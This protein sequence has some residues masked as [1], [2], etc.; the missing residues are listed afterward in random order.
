MNKKMEKKLRNL[1]WALLFSRI[2]ASAWQN[3]MAQWNIEWYNH[4]EKYKEL[5]LQTSINISNTIDISKNIDDEFNKFKN[6]EWKKI[7]EYYGWKT[8]L[9]NK[10]KSGTI[11]TIDVWTIKNILEEILRNDPGKYY[12][13]ELDGYVDYYRDKYCFWFSDP[14]LTAIT[15]L[16]RDVIWSHK[17]QWQIDFISSEIKR[18]M[19]QEILRLYDRDGR[20]ID[21][22]DEI[23]KF[24]QLCVWIHDKI[25]AKLEAKEIWAQ[26]V[27]WKIEKVLS[28]IINMIKKNPD[29]YWYFLSNWNFVI[30]NDKFKNLVLEK[31]KSEFKEYFEGME[32]SW[33]RCLRSIVAFM[34][35][36][37]FLPSWCMVLGGVLA[38]IGKSLADKKTR[39]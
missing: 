21:V 31:T 32:I 28:E 9:E 20:R 4:S 3:A 39:K 22:G 1:W 30:N 10:I 19:P 23:D 34:V 38:D 15:K 14:D 13:R 12:K 18:N 27:K 6:W 25:T 2:F 5:A 8:N 26:V 17:D 33:G 29:D 24:N 35:W 36:A 16:V 37:C 7:I 11:S